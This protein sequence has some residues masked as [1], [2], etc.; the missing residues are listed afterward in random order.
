MIKTLLDRKIKTVLTVAILMLVALGILGF[1]DDKKTVEISVD[2]KILTTVTDKKKVA[3]I[4]AAENIKL[5]LNDGFA[6]NT[7]Y[8]RD[9]SKIEVIRAIPLTID[10][11]G[12]KLT[13]NSGLPTVADVLKKAGLPYDGMDVYPGLKVRPTTAQVIYVLGESEKLVTMEEPVNFTT[14]ELPDYNKDFGVRKILRQGIWGKKEVMYKVAENGTRIPVGEKILMEPQQEVVSAGRLGA[15]DTERGVFKYRQVY[16]ME[17][18]AYTPDLG[19]YGSGYTATGTLAA[20]GQVA[21]DPNVIALGTKLYIEGYGHAIATDT[22]GHIV[23][24]RIDVIFD[25]M[26]QCYAFGRRDVKV[27]VLE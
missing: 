20:P 18:T 8:V 17:A 15:I 2:G 19:G 27:Y 4:L 21:V 14:K 9:G 22:G 25:E 5:G 1:A 11:Q 10:Y 23:G 16:T 24:N 7:K 26:H 6:M 3:E 13:V 12:K